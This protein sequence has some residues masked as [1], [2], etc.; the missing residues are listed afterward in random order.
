MA[1]PKGFILYR[2]WYGENI[3]YLG[4]TKQPLQARIRGHLLK[5]PMHRAI[6]IHNVTTI[7]YAEFQTEADMFLYEIYF[8]NLWKPPLNVDDKAH[9]S[10]TFALPEVEW[11][12]FETPLWDKWKKEIEEKDISYQNKRKSVLEAFK[13]KNE[14]YKKWQGGEISEEQYCN[15]LENYFLAEE[16]HKL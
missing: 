6:D 10:L 16:D 15:F 9:D 8:I 3:A 11:K 14:M 2:I 7:E 13:K 4:R 12:L 1:N 5:K